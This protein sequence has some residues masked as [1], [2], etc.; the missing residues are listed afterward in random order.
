MVED[1]QSEGSDEDD[2][3]S[4]EENTGKTNPGRESRCVG[5]TA[6][7]GLGTG[8]WPGFPF[9]HGLPWWHPHCRVRLATCGKLDMA[10]S[11]R[12][13]DLASHAGQAWAVV[14]FPHVLTP[15]PQ[16]GTSTW[17]LFF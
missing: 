10:G 8:S 13:G 2:S 6:R 15:G 4:G 16:N 1:L 17:G 7:A 14:G 11:W 3:S 9:Q 5:F 12:M